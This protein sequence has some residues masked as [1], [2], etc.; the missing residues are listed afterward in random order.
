MA[1]Q[2]FVTKKYIKAQQVYE[3]IFP[4]YK[5]DRAAFEDIYYKYAYCAYNMGDY[6]NAENLLRVLWRHF[7]QAKS[8]RRWIT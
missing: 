7:L 6:M 2:F 8:R 5:T 3:D 4:Y 1:E